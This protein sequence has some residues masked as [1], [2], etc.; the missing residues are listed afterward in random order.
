ESR[1]TRIDSPRTSRRGSTT[2]WTIGAWPA[3]SAGRAV[4][5]S[6]RSSPGPGWPR[7]PSSCTG[8]WAATSGDLGRGYSHGRAGRRPHERGGSMAPTV[9]EGRRR[10]VIEG[11]TPEMDAGRFPIKRTIDEDVVVEANI[12]AD[13]HDAL[14]AVLRYRR[15]EDRAWSETPME[16]LLNDRWRG[17]FTVTDL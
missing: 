1:W 13:G 15:E 16:P 11:V 9:R 2:C 14:R 7:T 5:A 6:W 17:R 12:F 3:G 4:N 10:V 8:G